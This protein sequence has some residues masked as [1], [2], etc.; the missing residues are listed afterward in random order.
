VGRPRQHAC[1]CGHPLSGA[2]VRVNA[3]GAQV[4]CTCARRHSHQF[5]TRQQARRKNKP[6]TIALVLWGIDERPALLRASWT[7]HRTRA[8][9]AKLAP[10]DG[11]PFSIVDV[12][13]KP[14]IKHRWKPRPE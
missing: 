1:K 9:A 5:R 10:D 13:R 7:Y 6:A 3:N 14:W 8:D 12:A 11:T 4:C 2:N